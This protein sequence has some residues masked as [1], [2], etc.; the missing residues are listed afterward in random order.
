M[1]NV[2]ADAFCEIEIIKKVSQKK[3]AIFIE[4]I[5][6]HDGYHRRSETTFKMSHCRIFN[7]GIEPDF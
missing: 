7:V 5:R 6:V 1:S 4:R 3:S 2:K